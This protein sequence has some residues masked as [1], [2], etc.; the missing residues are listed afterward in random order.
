MPKNKTFDSEIIKEI[1]RLYSS[2][3]CQSK[4]KIGKKF[5]TSKRIVSKIL[6]DNNVETVSCGGRNKI[7]SI[8]NGNKYEATDDYEFVAKHKITGK[9]FKDYNNVS[10]ALIQYVG[11]VNPEITIPSKH[12]RNS[13]YKK[14]GNYWYEQFF[15]IVRSPK[16]D[17][18]KRGALNDSDISEIVSLY[19]SGEVCSTHKLAEMFGVGHKKI[20]TVLKSNGVLL[21]KRGGF[22]IY[23]NVET[24]KYNCENGFVYRAVHKESGDIFEDYNNVSGALTRYISEK[25][26]DFV[27]PVLDSEKKK[28]FLKTGNYWYEQFFNIVKFS[29]DE[30]SI[31]K[32]PYCDVLSDTSLSFRKY[33]NHLIKEHRID[34][35]KH[36]SL[37]NEDYKIFKLEIIKLNKLKNADNWVECKIC[38]KKMGVVSASHLKK[39]NISVFDYKIK[40]GDSMSLTYLKDITVRMTELNRN[41]SMI[42][43]ISK[44]ELTIRSFLD[45]I[46]VSYETNRSVLIGKEIDILSHDYK[47]GIEFNGNK[48]HTEWFGKKD[49]N[50]HLDKTKACNVKGY[51]LIH[52]FEDELQYKKDIVFAKLKHIFNKDGDLEKIAARK[53]VI[54]QIDSESKKYFLEKFHI[55]GDG[56]STISIGSYYKDTLIAV[57]TFKVVNKKENKFELTRFASDYNYIHQGVG[58]KMLSYFIKTFKPDSIVSFA[59]RRWTVNETDNLYVKL[60]FKLVGKT[61]PDYRYYNEKMDRY[62]RFHKFGFRKNILN[63]KYGLDL[64]LTE[65]EMVKLIGFDR[66]WDCG[67]FKYEWK[68]IKGND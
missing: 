39:H 4:E 1:V 58:S 64:S 54:K 62:K 6:N 40:Y 8:V 48:W 33:K 24:D 68:K 34:I 13:Y 57:M 60:G 26:P 51:G 17:K 44:P 59:D 9:E 25:N 23:P 18:K 35:E 20:S 43:Y 12:L 36:V 29:I 10:G 55:Q 30:L 7:N 42:T 56:Q 31:K 27:I 5:K 65:T 47:L 52:I 11:E 37:H 53:C 50:Y 15:D 22:R 28:Y 2:G 41:G 32:C 49:K 67:L 46:G 66:I 14:T 16:I 38:G 19:S 63:K 45:E 61:L 3:E 21:N